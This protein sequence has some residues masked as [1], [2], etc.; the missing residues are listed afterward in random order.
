MKLGSGSYS[1]PSPDGK[2]VAA[3]ASDFGGQVSLLPTGEGQSRTIR[4]PSFHAYG[5]TWL[6]YAY[7][8]NRQISEL[9]VA[10]GIK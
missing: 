1:D 4:F 5:V 10:D 7:S 6:P 2:W 9:F 3:V 8:Y